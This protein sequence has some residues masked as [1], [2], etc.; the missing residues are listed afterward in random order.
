[1]CLFNGH[2]LLKMKDESDTD[3]SSVT[4]RASNMVRADFAPLLTERTNVM[5]TRNRLHAEG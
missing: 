2:R 5:Q 4:I 3:L 1:M